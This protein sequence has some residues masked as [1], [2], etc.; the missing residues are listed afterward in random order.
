M[1]GTLYLYKYFNHQ[2][3][4]PGYTSII[5]S[6]WFLGG[7]IIFILGILG[8]YISKTFDAVKNRPYYIIE[9]KTF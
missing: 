3:S 7:L 8:L 5:I 6:I 2:I 4:V 9:K 1:I